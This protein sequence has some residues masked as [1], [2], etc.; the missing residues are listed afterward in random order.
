MKWLLAI[1]ATLGPVNALIAS[2][3]ASAGPSMPLHRGTARMTSS[4]VVIIK[5]KK[6]DPKSKAPLASQGE[7]VDTSV[8]PLTAALLFGGVGLFSLKAFDTE[9]NRLEGADVP[10]RKAFTWLGLQAVAIFG[11]RPQLSNPC[12]NIN[13]A[14]R[15]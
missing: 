5:G 12:S 10:R 4:D 7:C 6:Y 9:T 15:E 2:P 8:D 13:K 3:L 11:L 14:Y 1:F